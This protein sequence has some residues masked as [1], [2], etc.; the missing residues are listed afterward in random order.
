MR[1]KNLVTWL[2]LSWLTDPGFSLATATV[3]AWAS[4]ASVS[5]ILVEKRLPL[6]TYA[7]Y[8][9][10]RPILFRAYPVRP[11]CVF[12][13]RNFCWF[14]WVRLQPAKFIRWVQKLLRW[15]LPC[16]L[17][18]PLWSLNNQ[19]QQQYYT[20]YYIYLYIWPYTHKIEKT[21][22]EVGE[23]QAAA[24]YFAQIL[25]L[26]LDG[27]TGLDCSLAGFTVRKDTSSMPQM[28]RHHS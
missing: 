27:Q 2:D 6:N 26:T 4:G 17:F 12:T 16:A 22:V 24:A 9:V 28:R 11:K 14:C 15:L 20:I 5:G 23:E 21:M 8:F 10:P 18:V 1:G 25:M 19:Q 7:A 3:L 13:P